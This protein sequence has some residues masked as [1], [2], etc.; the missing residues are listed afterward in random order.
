[1]FNDEYT[2]S[3]KL[4][5]PIIAVLIITDLIVPMPYKMTVVSVAVLLGGLYFAI[6]IVWLIGNWRRIKKEWVDTT[7]TIV[8]TV[9]VPSLEYHN[10]YNLL[11]TVNEEGKTIPFTTHTA[12]IWRPY[13]GKQLR[14]LYDRK[15]PSDFLIVPA[16]RF[17]AA[18]RLFMTAISFIAGI[19]GIW[20]SLR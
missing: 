19:V 13:V 20:I 16:Y 11:E 10:A 4:T 12:M 14:V 2:L 3:P 7:A 8:K 17:E 5:Y 9:Q 15:R 6:P 18:G 1:M